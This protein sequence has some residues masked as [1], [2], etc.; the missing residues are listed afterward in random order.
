M[1]AAGTG[2]PG[3][4][5]KQLY[6]PIGIYILEATNGLYIADHRNARVQKIL[7]NQLGGDGSTII[8]DL[9]LPLHVVVDYENRKPVIY[10][11]LSIEGRVAKWSTGSSKGVQIGDSCEDCVGVSVDSAKNVYVTNTLGSCINKWSPETNKTIVVA[12][13][14]GKSGVAADLLSI[15]QGL[16]VTTTGDDIYV[17]DSGNSR[18]QKWSRNA[19]QGVTVAGSSTGISGNDSTL[20]NSPTNVVF[21]ERTKVLYIADTY[22]HRIQRWLPDAIQG[23]I[24]A[25][26]GG[27]L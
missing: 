7:L 26:I 18:I 17:A 27:M 8:K 16:Y 24:I 5:S 1:T 20:L 6:E 4:S 11:T 13:T 9:S 15:P 25:G 10:V 21:D 3:N 12:G 14:S 22:N 2:I 19:Q 23:D